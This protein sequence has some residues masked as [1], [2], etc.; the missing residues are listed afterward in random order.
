M[1]P[2]P[3]SIQT[4]QSSC[5]LTFPC[6]RGKHGTYISTAGGYAVR[7]IGKYYVTEDALHHGLSTLKIRET[8]DEDEFYTRAKA[9][10]KAEIDGLLHLEKVKQ[11]S[12]Q[13]E[14]RQQLKI[15]F[16]RN[17]IAIERTATTEFAKLTDVFGPV[18]SG[19]VAT[20]VDKRLVTVPLEREPR[21]EAMGVVLRDVEGLGS[22]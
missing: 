11:V 15:I 6:K 13:L 10:Y 5:R 21:A 14:A 8:Y 7:I 16:Q 12:R 20:S 9:W 4:P 17:K 2:I 3:A 19:L 18:L 22:T 1:G